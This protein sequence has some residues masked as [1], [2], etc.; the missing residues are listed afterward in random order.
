MYQD[1]ETG[2]LQGM[3]KIAV[4]ALAAIALLLTGCGGTSPE[5]AYVSAVS[6][7]APSVFDRGSEQ[8]LV[9]LGKTTCGALDSGSTE[10]EMTDRYIDLGFTQEDA[11]A[12]VEEAAAHLC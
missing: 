3:T 7:R 10:Q 5:D 12:V 1:R 2:T 6:D 8:E 9:D 4:A 11:S